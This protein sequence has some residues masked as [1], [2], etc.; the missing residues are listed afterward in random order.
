MKIARIE[1]SYLTNVPITPPPLLKEPNRA[2]VVIV[3]VETDTGLVGYGATGG[4]LPWS[5][6]SFINREAAPALVGEDPLLT[7][8]V[9]TLMLKRF[10]QRALTGVWSFATS[11]ID[12]ALWDIKGK[13]FG[14]PV[15]R[16]LGGAQN[17][18]PAYITFGL[19]HYTREQ[20][21]EAAKFW[22]SQG[23]DK[24]KMVV[25]IVGNSQDP[26]ED[27]ARVRTV[28]EA[29]GPNVQ[30]MMD[31]NYLMSFHH[32]LRLCKLC[33]PLNMTWFEEPVYQNDA[34]LLADLRRQTTIPISAGQN[35]GHRWRHRELLVHHSV[36]I[37]QPNVVCVG[38]Y[39]E[40]AKV[41]G[42]AQA[43]NIPI[44][45]GGAWPMHNMHLQA[46]MSNGW[47]VEFHYLSWMMY[48]SV[49]QSVP[50]PVKGWVTVPE[51]PGLG[52]DPKPGIIKE[53]RTPV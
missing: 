40:A 19:P 39:T 46:G 53:Y 35:E 32:A 9:W 52:L 38:G 29:V 5:I 49:Y 20:L 6:V 28:R 16:L 1:A 22:V 15:W 47:R 42:M 43:F 37:L 33:E 45:N 11:A 23:Q 7:E 25:G 17:P 50:K 12:I 10:N 34:V 31:A 30:L 26:D 18:V 27:F 2:S 44:A 13:C 48:E 8:R 14:Q 41:A 36:D 24:L 3:E 21:A 4:M 51:T